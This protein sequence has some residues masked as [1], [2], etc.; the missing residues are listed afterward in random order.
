MSY[1]RLRGHS[2]DC[3]PVCPLLL[4]GSADRCGSIIRFYIHKNKGHVQLLCNRCDCGPAVKCTLGFSD[5]M[6]FRYKRIKLMLPKKLNLFLRF[7]LNKVYTFLPTLTSLYYEFRLYTWDQFGQDMLNAEYARLW[8]TLVH[9]E[10]P[11]YE[12]APYGSTT[13]NFNKA[14]GKATV[15]PTPNC[16]KKVLVWSCKADRKADHTAGRPLPT[17]RLEAKF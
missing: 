1:T 14:K 5:A 11:E 4:E 2:T 10:D 6:E 7:L 12:R 15:L 16:K 17:F 3:K 13:P 9:P 8:S